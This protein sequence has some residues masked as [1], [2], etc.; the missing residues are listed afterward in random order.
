MVLTMK[1]FKKHES[2]DRLICLLCPHSCQIRPGERGICGVRENTGSEI[3]LTTYGVISGFALDPVEKKPLYHFYPGKYIMSAGSYGCNLKCDFCQNY[4]ISQHAGREGSYK[5]TPEELVSRSL[6]YSDNI[7]IA[8]TYNEP[9]IWYE[10]VVDCARLASAAGLKNVMVTNGYV[11]SE[12]LAG[13]IGVIDAFNVDLK[14]FGNDFYRKCTG[15]TL[16]PVMDTIRDIASS[17]RHLE[18][19]TLIIPGMNDSVDSMRQ[20]AEWIATTA[21]SHVPLH[22]SRYFPMYKRDDPPTPAETILGLKET[23]SEYLDY[24]YTGNMSGNDSG[25]DTVCPGCHSTVI[26]RHGYHTLPAG[27]SGEGKCLKCNEVIVKWI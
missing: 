18:I 14:A 10:Y 8:F 11:N 17:G 16:K 15:A 2:N 23:A 3:T 22:L 19:T 9:V 24:V 20:E 21:G 5:L 13:L 7:G 25:S 1:L 26:K 4:Q 6:R 27:L 12:P